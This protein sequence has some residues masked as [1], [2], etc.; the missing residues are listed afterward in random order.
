MLD[1]DQLQG[2]LPDIFDNSFAANNGIEYRIVGT[3]AAILHGVDLPAGD[4]DSLL[5]AV[6]CVGDAPY[7]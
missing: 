3:A 7:H 5:K 4:I 2:I 6:K 1:F